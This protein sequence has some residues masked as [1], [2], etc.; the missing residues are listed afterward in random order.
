[1]LLHQDGLLVYLIVAILE[2]LGFSTS[3][4]LVLLMML[5]SL[6][7]VQNLDL[8]LYLVKSLNVGLRSLDIVVMIVCQYLFRC[9]LLYFLRDWCHFYI[10]SDL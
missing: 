9:L 5:Y 2:I 3:L 10:H 1:V 7:I 8:V 4:T 6:Q